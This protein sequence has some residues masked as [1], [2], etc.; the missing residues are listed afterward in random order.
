MTVLSYDWNLI[1]NCLKEKDDF[2]LLVGVIKNS[3]YVITAKALKIDGKWT[4]RHC[5]ETARHLVN[6]HAE[7]YESDRLFT[8]ATD[9][10]W[11]QSSGKIYL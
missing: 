3:V 10:Y 6:I 5:E 9:S 2:L 11:G 4:G 1:E 8:T 7:V